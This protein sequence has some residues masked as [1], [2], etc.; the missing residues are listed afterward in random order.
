M[1]DGPFAAGLEAEWLEVVRRELDQVRERGLELA[2]VCAI[3]LGEP[4]ARRAGLRC[5]R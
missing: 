3:E 4:Q 1:Y 2:A 5:A